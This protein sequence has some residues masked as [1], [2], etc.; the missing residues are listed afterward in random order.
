VKIQDDIFI[1]SFYL[2]RQ[3]VKIKIERLSLE[4]I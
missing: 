4:F 3:Y 1:K 2:E